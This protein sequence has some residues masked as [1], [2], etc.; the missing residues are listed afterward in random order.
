MYSEELKH[1]LRH[2]LDYLSHM[3]LEI[4]KIK[5]HAVVC[6]LNGILNFNFDPDTHRRKRFGR[7]VASLHFDAQRMSQ[8]TTDHKEKQPY[9]GDLEKTLVLSRLFEIPMEQRD[10]NWQRTFFD[11]VLDASFAATNPQ[12]IAGPDGFPYFQLNIPE[13]GVSFQCFVI[14]HMKDDFLMEQGWGIV[15]H[16]SKSPPDWVFSHG[17]IVNFHLRNEF[18]TKALQPD[19]PKQEIIQKEEQVL[20]AQPSVSFLPIQT[21]AVLRTFLTH[22]GIPDAKLLLMSRHTPAGPIQ[23]LVFNMTPEKFETQEQYEN[24]M[25]GIGW[26]LPRHYTYVAMS[27]STFAESFSPL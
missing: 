8:E 22:V 13:A 11:N 24:V 14:R 23:E 12:V 25:R 3:T 5:L 21:R 19:L 1:H 9:Y 7:D 17:D 2:D 16:A 6:L 18:Y 26:F 10:E 4:Q 27:E 20:V 15:I